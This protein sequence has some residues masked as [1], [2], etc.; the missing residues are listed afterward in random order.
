MLLPTGL[1]VASTHVT[2]GEQGLPQFALLSRQLADA[3][4][5]FCLGGDFNAERAVVTQAVG[6][7]VALSVLPDGSPRTRPQAKKNGGTD[8]DHLLA[9]HATLQD[10]RVLDEGELSDHRPVLATLSFGA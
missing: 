4:S 7:E 9:R 1:T 6:N 5:P 10:A 3:P 8:I 2:W